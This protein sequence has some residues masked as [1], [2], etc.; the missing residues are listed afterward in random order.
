MTDYK[1]LGASMRALVDAA[2]SALDAAG[3]PAGEK[4]RGHM[5]RVDAK[6]KQIATDA[7]GPLGKLQAALEQLAE[8]E[9]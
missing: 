4:I 8:D 9:D 7:G 3:H 5:K 2:A 6:V 1:K